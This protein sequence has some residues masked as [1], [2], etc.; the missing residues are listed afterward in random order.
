MKAKVL[1]SDKLFETRDNI[2]QLIG[3]KCGKCTKVCFPF[4]N[5][6][7][8]CLNDEVERVY[9]GNNGTIYSFTI[10]YMDSERYKAPYALGWIL[11][12]NGLRIFGQIRGWETFDLKIGM[13]ME[14]MIGTLWEEEE[15]EV[16]GY[17]FRPEVK[18]ISN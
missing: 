13:N 18:S 3:S 5:I 9:L 12:Q 16:I 1:L 14:I 4:K 2:L 11:L 15:K 6:C 7:P 8:Y 17:F 10:V